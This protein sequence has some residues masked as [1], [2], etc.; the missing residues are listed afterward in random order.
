MVEATTEP[1]MLEQRSLRIVMNAQTMA[2]WLVLWAGACGGSGL[3]SR[4][5][6]GAGDGAAA[7]ATSDAGSMQADGRS[8]DDGGTGGALSDAVAGGSGGP[9]GSGPGSPP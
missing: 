9:D 1:A 3:K 4:S 2:V 6:A 7:G 5:E 8:G